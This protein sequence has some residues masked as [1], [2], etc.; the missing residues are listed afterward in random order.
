M[1]PLAMYYVTAGSMHHPVLL[2][3]YVCVDGFGA[4][5]STVRLSHWVYKPSNG[6]IVIV[7]SLVYHFWKA[8][9]HWTEAWADNMPCYDC[10]RMTNRFWFKCV[11]TLIKS[12]IFRRYIYGIHSATFPSY[13]LSLSL[14]LRRPNTLG[15][16]TNSETSWNLKSCDEHKQNPLAKNKRAT[17]YF[18]S[19]SRLWLQ[20]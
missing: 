15:A 2:V 11:W 19:E 4:V 16:Y 17:I 12:F 20:F 1:L 9:C 8:F 5:K 14:S 6:P 18:G 3:K 10:T 7:Y 13:P